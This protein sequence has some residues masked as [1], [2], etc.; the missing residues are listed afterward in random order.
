MDKEQSQA[1][2]I[3]SQS[4]LIRARAGSGKTRVI[5]SLAAQKMT[6]YRQNPDHIL[7]LAFNRKAANEI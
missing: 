5:T 1:M 3:N 4:L 2:S 6:I 7:I